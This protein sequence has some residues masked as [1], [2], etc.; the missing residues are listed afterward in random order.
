[1]SDLR[2]NSSE[3]PGQQ[4]DCPRDPLPQE[5]PSF[6]LDKNFRQVLD[7]DYVL[8]PCFNSIVDRGMVLAVIGTTC[9]IMILSPETGVPETVVLDFRRPDPATGL[10]GRYGY[11]QVQVVA[12]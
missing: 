8:L 2:S 3:D 10:F 7:G 9:E 6:V 4:Q 11:V 1:M 5:C 12:R